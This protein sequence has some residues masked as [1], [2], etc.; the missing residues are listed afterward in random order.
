GGAANLDINLGT[1]DGNG[2]YNNGEHD[3]NDFPLI[4]DVLSVR[5]GETLTVDSSLLLANDYDPNIGDTVTIVADGFSSADGA[6]SYDQNSGEIS[7]TPNSNVT[8]SAS[9]TYTIVDSSGL[10][11]SATVTTTVAPISNGLSVAA[12]LTSVN[13]NVADS[14]IAGI[15]SSL[16]NATVDPT[17]DGDDNHLQTTSGA[18]VEALGGNDT[19]VYGSGDHM[20]VRGGEGEDVI[21]GND[22]TSTVVTENLQGGDGSD[23]LVGGID[24]STSINLL[25]DDTG[26]SGDD[27]LISRSPTT[28]T[29]YYGGSGNDVAY[30]TGQSTD[31]TFSTVGAP[32]FRSTHTGT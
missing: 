7:F 18:W 2:N 23:I 1:V 25:G 24:A 30:L 4:G 20:Q 22:G 21:I 10:T 27:V 12:N 16:A 31:Y 8:G 14:I 26:E 15:E 9:F 28:S 13:G 5:E 19:V 3:L 17:A 6:V 11:S 29:A 32:D